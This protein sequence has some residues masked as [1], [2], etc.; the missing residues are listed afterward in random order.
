LKR[1]MGFSPRPRRIYNY[2]VELKGTVAREFGD[3]YFLPIS[4]SYLSP[5]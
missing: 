2:G 3:K 1:N 5:L 4:V